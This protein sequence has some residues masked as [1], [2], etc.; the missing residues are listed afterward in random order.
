MNAL[1]LLA[2]QLPSGLIGIVASIGGLALMYVLYG[3][4]DKNMKPRVLAVIAEWSTASTASRKVETEQVVSSHAGQQAQVEQRKA[5]IQ[6]VVSAWHNA[7]EQVASRTEFTRKVIDNEVARTDGIIHT[8]IRTG[9]GQV[10]QPLQADMTEIKHLL[11]QKAYDDG[12]F[13]HEVIS[14]LAHME[15]YLSVEER[16]SNPGQGPVPG[17]PQQA[18]YRPGVRSDTFGPPT[19]PVGERRTPVQSPKKDQG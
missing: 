15:G 13:R 12:S 16:G 7:P 2:D 5:E 4:W 19:G 8:S 10:V 3:I 9:M 14:R 18:P 6:S 1:P 17:R 11:T